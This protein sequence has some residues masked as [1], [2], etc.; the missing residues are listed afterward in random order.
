MSDS[1]QISIRFLHHPLPASPS[2]FLTVCLPIGRRYG[3]TMFHVHNKNGLDPAYPPVTELSVCSQPKREQPATCL[4]WL[5]PVS[6]FGLSFL[7][8]FISSSLTLV[9][10][11]SLVLPP[12]WRSQR[13]P[14][15]RGSGVIRRWSYIVPAAS[16]IA[17]ASDACAS[18]LLL[19][20][21]QVSS[22]STSIGE[23][24]TYATS[25]RTWAWSPLLSN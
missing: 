1:L 15:P 17:V 19:T 4:F 7:T 24:I 20:E 2:A 12:H 25:C 10:P 18:R 16:H 14:S 9:I 21:Q 8:M 13:S 22:L 6:V 11:S 3:L 23:T 5:K